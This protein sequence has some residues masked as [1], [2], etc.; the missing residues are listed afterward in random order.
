VARIRTVHDGAITRVIIT[1]RITAADMGRIEHACA[2]ALLA[3][4]SPLELDLRGVTSADATAVAVLR[5][6]ASRGARVDGG[7]GVLE[8]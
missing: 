7:H 3:H 6:I 8:S 4:P 2:P 5:R 1:G